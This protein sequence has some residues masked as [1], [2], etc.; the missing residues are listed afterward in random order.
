MSR[1]L[2]AR[3]GTIPTARIPAIVDQDG[4]EV[5]RIAGLGDG[6]IASL[7]GITIQQPIRRASKS[8]PRSF[9]SSVDPM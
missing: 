1:K 2:M 6:T 3:I 8:R 5:A 7:V 9:R 4:I